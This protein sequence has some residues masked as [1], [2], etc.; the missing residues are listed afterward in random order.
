[1]SNLEKLNDYVAPVC[2]YCCPVFQRPTELK[3]TTSHREQVGQMPWLDRLLIKN[4]IFRYLGFGN[5]A[6]EA[7]SRGKIHARVPGKEPIDPKC[8]DFLSRFLDA[9]NSHPAVV[10]DDVVN[11]YQLLNIIAGS[12]TTA[13]SLRSIVYYILKN[14]KVHRN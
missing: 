13:I 6:F 2:F 5:S 9:K 1:M 4:P 11:N 7:Y 10:T 8:Q 3:L 12:D 14:P